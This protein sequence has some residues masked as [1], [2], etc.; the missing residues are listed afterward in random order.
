MWFH[1]RGAE[2]AVLEVAFLSAKWAINQLTLCL[3]LT[4]R[5]IVHPASGVKAR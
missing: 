4:I 5:S 3:F 2:S 1:V